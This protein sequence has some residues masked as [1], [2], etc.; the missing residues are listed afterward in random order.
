MLQ[1]SL[2]HSP[3][4]QTFCNLLLDIKGD[5]LFSLIAD[6]VH[7]F[8][9]F[10]T[11]FVYNG[12]IHLLSDSSF[13]SVSKLKLKYDPTTIYMNHTTINLKYLIN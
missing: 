12:L 2:S 4:L 5:K 3:S 8:D 13:V 11:L 1:I 10:H 6:L 7:L 9:P